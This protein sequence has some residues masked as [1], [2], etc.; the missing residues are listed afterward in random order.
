VTVE[1]VL[2]RARV[3]TDLGRYEDADPLVARVLAEEPDNADA[4]LLLIEG[5]AGRGRFTQ[6]AAAAGQLLRT[7]PHNMGGLLLMARM[8]WALHGAREGVSFARRAVELYPDD[9]T[10]LTTLADV[11]K[12]VTI[13]SVEALALI[14]NAIAIDPDYAFAHLVAGRIHL[15][16]LQ[17]VEAE[18]WTLQA[19]KN[20]HAAHT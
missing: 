14:E 12:E 7:D 6:A 5:Q 17:Y 20:R 18:N 11:L 8:Q 4:L 3:L 15:D 13:G 10:C 2:Q 9:V 19:L 1:D 16:A